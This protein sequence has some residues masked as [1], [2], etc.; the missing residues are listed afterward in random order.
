[1][2]RGRCIA[3]RRHEPGAGYG[4]GRWLLRRMRE[5]RRS[6]SWAGATSGGR[7]RARRGSLPPARGLGVRR[8][9]CGGRRLRFASHA[10]AAQAG[11][12]G[13]VRVAALVLHARQ[14]VHRQRN[15]MRRQS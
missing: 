15:A 8:R 7:E 1:M 11:P 10:R 5:G 3:I 9:R 6:V 4:S 2:S 13:P 12:G 14:S